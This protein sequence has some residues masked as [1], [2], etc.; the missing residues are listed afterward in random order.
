MWCGFNPWLG[1]FLMPQAPNNE[2]LK[3]TFYQSS[4][5]IFGK[6]LN[7]V[8]NLMTEQRR[9][10]EQRSK[11][12]LTDWKTQCS[13]NAKSP[14]IYQEIQRHSHQSP[15]RIFIKTHRLTLKLNE[16]GTTVTETLWKEEQS[17]RNTA[18]GFETHCKR[19]GDKPLR[20]RHRSWHPPPRG[21]TGGPER[22]T[23]TRPHAECQRSKGR[24]RKDSLATWCRSNRPSTANHHLDLHTSPET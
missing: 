14:Q 10:N 19:A 7:H 11:P 23:E 18:S 21:G 4:I 2:I 12:V 20:C 15:S 6:Q 9:P 8:Q 5:W 22:P 1:N 17:W 16:K 24:P 3:N 13:E